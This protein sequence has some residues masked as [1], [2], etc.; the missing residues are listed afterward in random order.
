M[1]IKTFGIILASAFFL[2]ACNNNEEGADTSIPSIIEVSIDLPE[3]SPANEQLDIPVQVT[4][5]GEPVDDARDVVI[6]IWED[7]DR[8]NGFLEEAKLQSDGLYQI[9]YEFESDGIYLVQAHV[10]ARD[11]HSMP[12]KPI[13]I[14]DV[15]EEDINAFNEAGGASSEEQGESNH[16]H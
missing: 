3:S 1:N 5:G 15:S 11:M 16:H 7:Q 14:G 4:Q 6:E 10:T 8:E 9:K 13:I 12:T 2:S